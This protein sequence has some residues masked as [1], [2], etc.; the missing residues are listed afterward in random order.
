MINEVT[1]VGRLG[2]DPEVRTTNSNN[3]VGNLWVATSEVSYDKDKNKIERTEWHTVTLWG[4]TA[5]NAAKFLAKGSLVYIKGRIQSRE[6]TDK[7]GIQRKAYE[8]V[9]NTIKYLNQ[10]K[11]SSPS[12]TNTNTTAEE[13]DVSQ[14]PW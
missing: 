3:S 1:L 12:N 2:K 11:D 10:K 6:Y 9:A 4:D 13:V 8:I 7:E 5:Q 14:I